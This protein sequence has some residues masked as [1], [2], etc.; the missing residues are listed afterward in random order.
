M[1]LIGKP[2]VTSVSQ[3]RQY[4]VQVNVESHFA[5]ET[6]QVEEVHTAA[7]GIFDSVA[8]SIIHDQLARTDFEIVG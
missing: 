4:C 1:E 7:Q 6:I 5:R 2:T 8:I 3:Y